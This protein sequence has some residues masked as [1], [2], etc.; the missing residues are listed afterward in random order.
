VS[1][2]SR[3]TALAG[4]AVVPGEVLLVDEGAAPELVRPRP[5]RMFLH[6]PVL[7]VVPTQSLAETI[8]A[9]DLSIDPGHLGAGVGGG[10]DEAGQCFADITCGISCANCP[11][12]QCLMD[13]GRTLEVRVP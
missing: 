10:S 1:H 2:Y 6:T 12:C 13:D 9:G 7:S 5:R 3:R 11:K 4:F 8:G